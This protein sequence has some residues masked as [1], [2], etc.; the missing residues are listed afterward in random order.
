MY[1]QTHERENVP[2]MKSPR[3]FFYFYLFFC[4]EKMN[5]EK[6]GVGRQ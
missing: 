1:T 3:S 5:K 2:K 6:G 4:K